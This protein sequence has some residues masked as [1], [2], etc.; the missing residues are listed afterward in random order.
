MGMMNDSRLGLRADIGALNSWGRHRRLC[1]DRRD[2]R[3]PPGGM[4][5]IVGQA[6]ILTP[7]CLDILI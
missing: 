4:G 5:V 6:G 2:A 3:D 1:R 7:V